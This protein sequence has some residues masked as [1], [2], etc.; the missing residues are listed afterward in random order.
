MPKKDYEKNPWKG[1]KSVELGKEYVVIATFIPP[2]MGRH[3][4]PY[5]AYHGNTY[6][7]EQDVEKLIKRGDTSGITIAMV[8]MQNLSVHR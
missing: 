1:F 4:E 2:Y 5:I 3:V 6:A 8:T 7:M